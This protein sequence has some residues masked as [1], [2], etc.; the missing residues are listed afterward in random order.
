[1]EKKPGTMPGVWHTWP[2]RENIH[3]PLTFRG[4]PVKYHPPR[5]Y[6][7]APPQPPEDHAMAKPTHP[8]YFP[9]IYEA[10]LLTAAQSK[11][12]LSI[13][14]DTNKAAQ[15]AR[16]N[17]YAFRNAIKRTGHPWL[18]DIMSLELL[19]RENTLIIRTRGQN[20]E[21]AAIEAALKQAGID[22]EPVK[23]D[24][25]FKQYE[26]ERKARELSAGLTSKG[27]AGVQPDYQLDIK[28]GEKIF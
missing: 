22:I 4:N 14:F 24:I 16:F 6:S 25:L 7:L 2:P 27:K 13:P 23:D 18:V 21:T 15:H 20:D 5:A 10:T 28:P 26:S 8:S 11:Q 9:A 3:K 12:P 1:M 19:I 17:F